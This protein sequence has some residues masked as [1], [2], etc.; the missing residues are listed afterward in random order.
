[1]TG[2][3]S[4]LTSLPNL[5]PA[6][7]HFPIAFALAALLFDVAS[8]LLRRQRW[9]ERCAAALAALA[10]VG[11][12]GAYLAGR[13]AAD[14]VGVLAPA[15]EAALG[16]HA[17]LALWTLLVLGAAAVLRVWSSVRLGDE[18]VARATGTRLAGFAVLVVGVALVAVTADRGGALVFRHGVAVEAAEA[19]HH[20]DGSTPA[21]RSAPA[22]QPLEPAQTAEPT[23]S[24][25]AASQRLVERHDGTEE[26][27]PL[28]GDG[29]FLGR[30]V[31]VAVTSGRGAW[32][33]D[34][35]AGRRGLWL[36]VDGS[37]VL[38]LPKEFDNLVEEARLD[39]SQLD[40][41][42]GLVHHASGT[43]GGVVFELATDG[44]AR[45][46]RRPGDEVLDTG[47]AV[48]PDG[49]VELAASS[50]EGHHQK[51]YVDGRTVVHGHASPGTGMRVGLL[52]RGTGSIGIER[53][54]A[55]PAP[56][57][58]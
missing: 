48:L 46:V 43:T 27:C 17:D 18:P 2:L 5:H 36:G 52:I 19:P 42:V 8:L 9:L 57:G 53:L 56:A 47:E 54:A 55:R 29:E 41:A 12:G 44:A 26:W 22:S 51:G 6:V 37:A 49:P 13:A 16:R 28:D 45:L 14:S 39:L 50:V 11:A 31:E 20:A 30:V 7:V 4:Q 34:P 33:V 23:P 1:M 38:L 25:A 35:P 32:P 40:G 21:P 10:A 15:A 58:E 24:L 3:A